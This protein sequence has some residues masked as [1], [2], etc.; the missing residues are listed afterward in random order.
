MSSLDDYWYKRMSQ[1]HLQQVVALH[2]ECFPGYYLT[3]LGSSFLEAMYTWYVQSPE[4]IAHVALDRDGNVVGFVA[5]ATNDSSYRTS[6]FR[7]GWRHMAIALGKRFLSEPASTLRLIC[8]RKELVWQALKTIVPGGSREAEQS[9]GIPRRK[10]PTASLTSIGVTPS[11]RGSRLGAALSELC[12]R[13]A[14]SRGC[15]RVTLS[16]REDNTAAR[17]FYESINW[18]EVSRSRR[19]YRGSQSI[20]YQKVRNDE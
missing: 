1:E 14:W 13:E 7:H 16:V 20:T 3:E 9:D 11:A 5:G 15:G 18:Q 17:R 2:E 4:A 19:I 10:S 6:L 12:V 8:E